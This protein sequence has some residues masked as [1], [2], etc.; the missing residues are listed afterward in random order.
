MTSREERAA[1]NEALFREVNERVKDVTEDFDERDA[2]FLCECVDPGCRAS[3][4]MTLAE[5]E[6]VRSRGDQ[7]AVAPGHADL[8]VE[9]VVREDE[10]FAV[11]RKVGEG[12][13]LAQRLN[14]RE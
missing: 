8:S 3:L 5:Y 13:V 7:F 10:R 1:R 4:P 12:A 11:V 2:T 6:E 14:P 9:R